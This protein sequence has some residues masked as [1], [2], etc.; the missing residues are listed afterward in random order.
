VGVT[1][2]EGKKMYF[3]TISEM[4]GTRGEEVAKEVAKR[5]G[6]TFYGD[7]ELSKTAEA[8]GFLDDVKKLDE[9]GPGIL[10]KFFS[11][12][13]KVYLDRFQSVIYEV[14]KKGDGVFFGKGS[15]LLLSSFGCAFHVLVTGSL[16]KR[17]ERVMEE[18]KVG[19]EVAEKIVHHSDHD[20][21]GFIRF[22]FDED[23][24][25]PH[26]YDLILN[27]DKLSVDSAV[28]MVVDAAKSDEI[29]ACGVDSI[30]SFGKLS[31]QRKIEAAILESGMIH[32]H[33]FFTVEDMETVRLYGIV[34]THEEKGDAE[35]IVKR[36]AG[37][38]KV[39]NDLSISRGATGEM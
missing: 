37:V 36:V 24:L 7:E 8:M 4:A 38:K 19:R 18:K 25:N 33:V 20:K 10:E 14:A 21:R 22:A 26:L 27:T 6:Y 15:Q 23:W 11:E 12:K 13:P 39:L 28:K 1:G 5:L 32:Q 31:L 29:K 34:H 2:K 35:K 3:I 30:Q 9:K 16:K 17:I